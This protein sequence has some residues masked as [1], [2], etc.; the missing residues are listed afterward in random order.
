[1]TF[2][3]FGILVSSLFGATGVLGGAFGAHALAHLWPE[4][5]NILKTAVQY[6]LLHAVAILVL[7]TAGTWLAARAVRVA[8]ICMT[9]GTFIFS[10]SLAL[11]AVLDYRWAGPITPFGGT[12]L[13]VGW[14][15]LG[16][17]RPVE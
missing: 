7:S 6:Q 5:A 10:T 12:L 16:F 14:V 2:R 4:R 8:L 17:Y 11:I 1:M 13:I 15:S 3:R 9:L